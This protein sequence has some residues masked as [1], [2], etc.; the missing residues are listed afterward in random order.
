[1][2]LNAEQARLE[3]DSNIEKSCI[4][5]DNEL[6]WIFS[7]IHQEAYAGNYCVLVDKNKFDKIYRKHVLKTLKSNGYNVS[8]DLL[9]N[10]Y[11][12]TWY[13]EKESLLK[14]I[15]DFFGF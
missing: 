10:D 14:R 8:Y 2:N 11:K 13:P 1:M 15:E 5:L 7:K 9:T 4:R 3:A 12:I 6:E